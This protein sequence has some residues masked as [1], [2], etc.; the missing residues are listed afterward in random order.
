MTYEQATNIGAEAVGAIKCTFTQLY[1]SKGHKFFSFQR[2]HCMFEYEPDEELSKRF[3]QPVL[4][5]R[6]DLTQADDSALF[7]SPVT[8]TGAVALPDIPIVRAVEYVPDQPLVPV[9]LTQDAID[10]LIACRENGKQKKYYGEIYNLVRNKVYV[11]PDSLYWTI[12]K[13]H[14]NTEIERL[15]AEMESAKK[16]LIASGFTTLI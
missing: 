8:K 10:W 6:P 1:D 5:R 13:M 2:V 4:V 9:Y 15:K 3:G 16:L 11:K 14:S 12:S 7:Y